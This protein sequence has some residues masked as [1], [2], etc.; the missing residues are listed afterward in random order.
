MILIGTVGTV[1]FL[2]FVGYIGDK[3]PSPV[4]VPLAFT[5]RAATAFTFIWIADPR[6]VTAQLMCSCLIIFT[7]LE[8]VSIEVLLMRGMPSKIRGTMMSLFGFFGLIGTIS[9][10]V[11]GG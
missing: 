8:S 11:I 4:L 10:T 7:V 9:Y 2:P 5:L 1:L 6:T 3:V